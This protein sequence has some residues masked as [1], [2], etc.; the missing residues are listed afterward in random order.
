M[1]YKFKTNELNKSELLKDIWGKF[2]DVRSV[3][4]VNY[5]VD[6]QRRLFS[7]LFCPGPN[8]SFITDFP[9]QEIEYVDEGVKDLLGIDRENVNLE[10]ILDRVHVDD[11]DFVLACEGKI[12]WFIDQVI[13]KSEML[14]Y[15]FSYTVRFNTGNNKYSQF[16]HQAVVLRQDSFGRI[17]KVL[18]VNSM[19][20]HISIRNNRKLSAIHMNGGQS[21]F[22][23]CPFT[24]GIES[25]PNETSPLT[26]REKDT[27]RQF[28]EGH[29]YKKVGEI[30]NVSP[31]TIRTHKQNILKKL[32][33][34][35]MIQVVTIGL[36]QG[37]M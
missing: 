8:V 2:D 24:D 4:S 7:N 25:G 30:L 23:I 29:D 33:A 14:L 32:K 1:Q 36:Q 34:K 3:T 26:E 6:Y 11:F 22:N 15:K 9:S 18:S 17:A 35:N 31:N 28:A 10:T 12:F 5:D 37:W 20:D 16:L 21:Y 27:V 19:I 13:K